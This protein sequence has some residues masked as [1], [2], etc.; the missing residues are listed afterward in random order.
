MELYCDPSL[1]PNIIEF[2]IS[3]LV[4]GSKI[5][6]SDLNLPNGASFV[7]KK[8]FNVASIVGRG[9]KEDEEEVLEDVG[10]EGVSDES[11]SPEEDPK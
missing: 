10:K 4:V 5:R 1:I 2:D 6:S 7:N 3:S 9:A 8:V 11:E